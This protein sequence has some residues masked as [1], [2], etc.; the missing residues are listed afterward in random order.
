MYRFHLGS[1][2]LLEISLHVLLHNCLFFSSERSIINRCLGS[3]LSAIFFSGKYT[4]PPLSPLC[5]LLLMASNSFFPPSASDL[6]Q[7]VL[8][9]NCISFHCFESL[10]T[11][12]VTIYV[13]S[14]Y[15]SYEN[16]PN[17]LAIFDNVQSISTPL[18]VTAEHGNVELFL[19]IL[20]LRPH[21]ARKR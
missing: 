17:V 3:H 14:F 2:R 15:N 13:P 12:M 19:E 20:N 8:A 1:Q 16:H 9:E 10:Y 6:M 5:L 4:P 7:K 18:H 11:A 21:F